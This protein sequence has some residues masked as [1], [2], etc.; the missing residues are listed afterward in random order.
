MTTYS[1]EPNSAHTFADARD[2]IDAI[3]AY[4]ADEVAFLAYAVEPVF[5]G[6]ERTL[7]GY[8]ARVSDLDGYTLGFLSPF[9]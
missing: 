7:V 9:A 6:G 2:A 3:S 1:V 5:E 8:K 4:E